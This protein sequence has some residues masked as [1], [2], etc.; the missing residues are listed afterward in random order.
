ML[1][2]ADAGSPTTPPDAGDLMVAGLTLSGIRASGPTAPGAVTLE[3]GGERRLFRK[4]FLYVSTTAARR[5]TLQVV[6]PP[7]ARLFYTDDTTWMSKLPDSKMI[8]LARQ[9]V[10]VDSC[11]DDLTG[12]FWRARGRADVRHVARPP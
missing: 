2:C 6:T 5:T 3:A 12:Y 7:D 4:I 8:E 9:A 1:S 10:T 11:S